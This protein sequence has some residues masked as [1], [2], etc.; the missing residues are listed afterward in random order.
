MKLHRNGKYFK[1]GLT[2]FLVIVAAIL[3]WIVFSNL[4]GFYDLFLEFTSII[5]PVI[6][7][8]LF[9]YLMN[10]IMEFLRAKSGKL[11]QKTKLTEKK[12]EKFSL[13][14]GV[15]GAMLVFL[16]AVY[17]IIALIVPNLYYSLDEL[18]QKE[19]LEKY[20]T[21]VEHWFGGLLSGTGVK[22]WF[23]ENVD[24][25]LQFAIAKLKSIDIAS[26]ISGLTSSVYS[27]VMGVFNA[28]VGIVAAIYLLIYKK[29]LCSQA[30]KIV[31]SIFTAQH[32]DRLFE[33]ARRTN[34]IFGGYVI[35]KI[36]DAFLVGVITYIA[37]VLM[38]M[39]Y[40]PLIATIIGVTNIIPF[41]GPFLGAIPSTLLLLIE[42]PINALY[43][44]IFIIVLQQIDGNIIENRILGE[45]LGIS[46]FWV[47]VAILLFGGIFGFGGMMLGVPIFA[48][49]Y[50][51]IAD[52]VNNR[53]KRRRYPT[54]SDLYY[55][56]KNVEDL[57]VE[58]LP[59]YSFVSVE[60]AYD[61]HA[62]PEDEDDYY[63]DF[64]E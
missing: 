34:R 57:P 49:L 42:R 44:V 55:T 54:D 51:L 1:W 60:P 38:G 46:D 30:K 50:T 52:G 8:C 5:S 17:A 11:L 18:L 7:G 26:I 47:L 15:V 28:L 2:A 62:E 40:A 12:R 9:A 24:S 37:M 4:S 64:D 36:I 16:A 33:I 19:K 20:Y 35:G 61:M 41:F 39:P 58:P 59:S 10:P 45:K 13:I 27:I 14:I 6:Y 25:V 21:T 29:P 63:S 43:F 31:V 48:V 3:F 22:Q 53:L 32:A 56:L 23:F